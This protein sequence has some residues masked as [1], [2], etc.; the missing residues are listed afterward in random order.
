MKVECHICEKEF[1]EEEC[2][3]PTVIAGQPVYV[4]KP[5]YEKEAKECNREFVKENNA[6]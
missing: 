6:S 5:C 4:C 1:E 2:E 3:I